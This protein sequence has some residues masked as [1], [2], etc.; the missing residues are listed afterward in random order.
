LD[1]FTRLSLYKGQNTK[2]LW[3]S[4]KTDKGHLAALQTFFSTV[5]AQ[6]AWPIPLHELVEVSRAT[7]QIAAVESAA[8]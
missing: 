1:D 5:A 3:Q 8:T 6:G 4:A 2:V 7:F